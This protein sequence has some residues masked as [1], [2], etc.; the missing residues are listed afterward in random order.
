MDL[1]I[2]QFDHKAM[3][4]AINAKA[5]TTAKPRNNLRMSINSARLPNG[6]FDAN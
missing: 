6:L 4:Q 2:A 3:P 1:T 5:A